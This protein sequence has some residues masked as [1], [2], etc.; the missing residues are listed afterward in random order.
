MSSFVVNIILPFLCINLTWESN[1]YHQMSLCLTITHGLVACILLVVLICDICQIYTPLYSWYTCIYFAISISNNYILYNYCIPE[2]FCLHLIF[3]PFC[4]PCHWANLK[5][6][7]FKQFLNYYNLPLILEFL[8]TITLSFKMILSWGLPCKKFLTFIAPFTSRRLILP[9]KTNFIFIFILDPWKYNLTTLLLA[10]K[11]CNTTKLYQV[12][13]S[14][15]NFN[16][17]VMYNP[18]FSL[19][20][21]YICTI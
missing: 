16:M 9:W 17:P 7:E 11:V 8:W 2:K 18:C 15:E 5:L 13:E 12:Y 4:P 3:Y 10:N 21:H 14:Y 1:N 20:R 6:G 19:Q